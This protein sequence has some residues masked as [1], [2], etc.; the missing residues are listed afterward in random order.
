M[1]HFARDRDRLKAAVPR[2]AT[3]PNSVA[4][5]RWLP[6]IP[7]AARA[8]PWHHRLVLRPAQQATQRLL[9]AFMETTHDCGRGCSPLIRKRSLSVPT[10]FRATIDR[11]VGSLAP[12]RSTHRVQRCSFRLRSGTEPTLVGCMGISLLRSYVPP[13]SPAEIAGPPSVHRATFPELARNRERNARPRGASCG[14]PVRTLVDWEPEH[15][16]PS[17][18]FDESCTAKQRL[19]GGQGM[20]AL[21]TL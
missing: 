4:W 17:R 11:V 10:W 5:R 14:P 8:P 2:V 1:I 15:T 6:S 9:V 18:C 20:F 13:W 21:A 3:A 19:A 12:T 16:R 7:S